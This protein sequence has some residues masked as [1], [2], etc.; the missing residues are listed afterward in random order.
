MSGAGIGVKWKD[1]WFFGCVFF[2]FKIWY[3]VN[4][5]PP[6]KLYIYWNGS[7]LATLLKV[8]S[9]EWIGAFCNR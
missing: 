6:F 2:S 9:W 3:Q 5:F 7:S 8:K 4:H 1:K